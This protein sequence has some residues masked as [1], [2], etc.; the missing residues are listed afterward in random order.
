MLRVGRLSTHL[1]AG[2]SEEGGSTFN[3][4]CLDIRLSHIMGTWVIPFLTLSPLL[5]STMLGGKKVVE[6]ASLQERRHHHLFSSSAP[7]SN[8]D[9]PEA[10]RQE[11]RWQHS[12]LLSSTPSTL[13]LGQPEVRV[14]RMDSVSD[15]TGAAFEYQISRVCSLPDRRKQ[16][17]EI[18]P[19]GTSTGLLTIL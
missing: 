16:K 12:S 4:S 17:V 6:E 9:A 7:S 3:H 11:R 15:H 5:P 19:P 1:W 10:S 8:M 13:L 18:N 2:S 14:T